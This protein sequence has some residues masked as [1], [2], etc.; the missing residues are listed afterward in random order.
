MVAAENPISGR[1]NATV[2]SQNVEIF[3]TILSYF[4]ILVAL[5]DTVIP[6]LSSG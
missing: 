4:D 6:L 3:E 2:T 5:C 1:Y